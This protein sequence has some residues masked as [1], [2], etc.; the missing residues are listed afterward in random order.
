[1]Y[2]RNAADVQCATLD[3][4]IIPAAGCCSST[5]NT[6]QQHLLSDSCSTG[7]TGKDNNHT[8]AVDNNRAI[9]TNCNSCSVAPLDTNHPPVLGRASLSSTAA[10]VSGRDGPRRVGVERHQSEQ[11]LLNRT[12][13]VSGGLGMLLLIGNMLINM[14]D[15][16][17][18]YGATIA[19]SHGHPVLQSAYRRHLGLLA[20]YVA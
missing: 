19:A 10:A 9:N 14:R 2:T 18:K 11:L 4:G 7:G 8:T 15:Y 6:T 12:P 20:G 13:V 1:M 16:G 3:S 5:S 17:Y